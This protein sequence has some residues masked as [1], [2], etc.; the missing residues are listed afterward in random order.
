MR[1]TLTVLALVGLAALPAA[2]QDM[3]PARDQY[4][5]PK[6]EYSPYADD[7]FPTN[8]FFGV[9]MPEGTVMQLQERAYTSPIWY[10]PG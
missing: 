5:G 8:V 6:R 10:T 4:E 2:A 3:L 9:T 7:H 1:T